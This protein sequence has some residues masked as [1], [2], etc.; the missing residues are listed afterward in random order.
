MATVSLDVSDE[1]AG[2]ISAPAITIRTVP[3]RKVKFYTKP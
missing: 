3:S 2:E 1:Q